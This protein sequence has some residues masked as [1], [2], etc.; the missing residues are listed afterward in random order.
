VWAL[1]GGP[2][3]AGMWGRMVVWFVGLVVLGVPT[4]WASDLFWRT[5]DVRSVEFARWLESVCTRD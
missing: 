5:V 2:E 3:S 4:V 1:V